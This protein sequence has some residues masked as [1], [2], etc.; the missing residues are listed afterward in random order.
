MP[1]NRYRGNVDDLQFRGGAVEGEGDVATPA[2]LVADSALIRGR[3]A[4][5][6]IGMSPDTEI[7]LTYRELAAL[8][9]EA[10]LKIT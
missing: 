1:M 5:A 4:R 10:V 2:R 3:N 9:E 6:P 8:I 7:R